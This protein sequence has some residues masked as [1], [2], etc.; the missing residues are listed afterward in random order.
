MSHKIFK[1]KTFPVFYFVNHTNSILNIVINFI[2]A[3]FWCINNKLFSI[4][5]GNKLLRFYIY[6]CYKIY[7]INTKL[8]LY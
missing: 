4:E 5:L 3:L 2:L 7:F 6:K 1:N 8:R